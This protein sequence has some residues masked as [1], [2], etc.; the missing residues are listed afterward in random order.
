M[1]GMIEPTCVQWNR[2]KD[3]GLAVKFVRLAG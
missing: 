1:A 3:A 2:W